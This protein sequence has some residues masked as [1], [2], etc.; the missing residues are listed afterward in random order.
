MESNRIY[1]R[2]N[3]DPEHTPVYSDPEKLV[4]W[5]NLREHQV[6]SPPGNPNLGASHSFV[7]VGSEFL[8]LVDI[9]VDSI[10][11]T[12]LPLEPLIDLQIHL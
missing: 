2:R 5:R 1:T 10:S 11:T 7:H 4:T 9:S 3:P 8:E 6:S 12:K